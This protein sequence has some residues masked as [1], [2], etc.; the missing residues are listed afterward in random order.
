M[1]QD[2][3]KQTFWQFV[4]FSIFSVSAG[5]IETGAYLLFRKIVGFEESISYFI[6]LVLSV[7][8]NFTVNRRFTFKSSSN[9]PLSMSKV[10]L[11]YCVFTPLSTWWVEVLTNKG[12]FEILVI[13]GTMII[14]FITEFL[15]TRFFVFR[16]SINTNDLAKK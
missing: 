6:G 7:L 12:W 1:N 9:I 15:Y 14:N 3:K 10:F 11:Y 16:K 5:I 13:G 2:I 8:Y 4:K